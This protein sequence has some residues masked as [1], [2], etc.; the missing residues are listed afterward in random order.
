MRAAISIPRRTL[1]VSLM[2][3]FTVGNLLSALSAKFA[4]RYSR[5]SMIWAGYALMGVA[6]AA[7]IAYNTYFV[8]ACL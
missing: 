2:L 7:N 1:L 5:T 6:A 3:V 4:A 8:A